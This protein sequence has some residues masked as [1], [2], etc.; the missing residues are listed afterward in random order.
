M[1]SKEP[2]VLFHLQEGEIALRKWMMDRV[3][4][5]IMGEEV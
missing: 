5:G 3:T 2:M 1:E 4:L